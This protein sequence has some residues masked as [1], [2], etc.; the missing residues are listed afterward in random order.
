MVWMVV[1]SCLLM[2]NSESMDNNKNVIIL[3][4]A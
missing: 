3:V 1:W 4:N 2:Q